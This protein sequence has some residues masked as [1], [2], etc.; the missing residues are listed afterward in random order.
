MT[1]SVLIKLVSK[2]SISELTASG[3][4]MVAFRTNTRVARYMLLLVRAYVLKAAN[5]VWGSRHKNPSIK[6]AAEPGVHL[7]AQLR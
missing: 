4:R 6:L 2:G 1:A 3:T 5:A 7:P